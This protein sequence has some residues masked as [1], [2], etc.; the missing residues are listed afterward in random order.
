MQIKTLRTFTAALIQQ[1][2]LKIALKPDYTTSR[3]KTV[4]GQKKNVHCTTFL[5]PKYFN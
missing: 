4:L 3:N 1:Y 2:L 5:Q